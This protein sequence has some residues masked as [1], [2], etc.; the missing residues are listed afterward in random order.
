MRL[1][2]GRVAQAVVVAVVAVIAATSATAMARAAAPVPE[3]KPAL[4]PSSGCGVEPPASP[5]A[6][7]QVDGRTRPLIAVVP[8]DYRPDRAHQLVI[9]FHG[10]TSPNRVVRSYF[11]LEPHAGRPTIFVYPSGLK[12]EDGGFTWWDDGNASED[13]RD[14]ALFDLLLERFSHLYCLDLDQVFAVGHSLGASFVNSLGC[15]RG[16]RLRA[17]ATLAGGVMPSPCR[18]PTAAVIFHN[19]NDQLVAFS[20]GLQTR[21]LYLIENGLDDAAPVRRGRFA[22]TR[23]GRPDAPDPVLWCPHTQNYSPHGEFYPHQW[24]S[25]AGAVIMRFFES[26]PPPEN[27]QAMAAG[28]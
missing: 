25:G 8:D 27:G 16:D 23:Y 1:G 14:F 9:A 2:S 19:P 11:G 3:P 20:Y 12:G 6:A 22:C 13:L 10:R 18:G 17:I 24:P 15:A 21:R 5:P 4:H 28:S 26:L 7:L